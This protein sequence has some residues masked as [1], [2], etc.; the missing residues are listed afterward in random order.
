[1]ILEQIIEIIAPEN[2]SDEIFDKL[3]NYPVKSCKD[4]FLISLSHKRLSEKQLLALCHTE[5]A[6]ECFFELATLYYEDCKYSYEVFSEFIFMFKNCRY[7]E[8]F[9]DLLEELLSSGNPSNKEKYIFLQNE[10]V[11]HNKTGN[12]SISCLDNN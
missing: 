10:Q 4:K 7:S 11:K 6:F 9:D 5:C 12:G 1:M 8:L 3:F 2:I